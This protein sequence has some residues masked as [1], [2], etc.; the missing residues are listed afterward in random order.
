MRALGEDQP[1]EP[2]LVPQVIRLLAWNQVSALARAYLERGGAHIAG[3]LRDALTDQDLDFGIRRRIPRLLA[4]VPSQ[5]SMESLIDGLRDQRFEVRQQC[6]RALESMHRHYPELRVP[7]E[8][9]LAAIDRELAVSPSVWKSRRLLDA[10]DSSDQFD[11]LD[12]GV[13]GQADHSLEHVFSLLAVVFAREPVLATF[14]ALHQQDRMFRGL[15]LEY[16]ETVLADKMRRR[17]WELL[18]EIPAV[19]QPG[20]SRAEI[21]QELMATNAVMLRTPKTPSSDAAGS[22]PKPPTTTPPSAPR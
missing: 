1:F 21:E 6:G 4:R 8:D 19:Q 12:Q 20:K 18:E 5:M 2:L 10:R 15:A 17:L 13:A 9:V 22:A 11:F 7:R 3:Q 14:R 16:L